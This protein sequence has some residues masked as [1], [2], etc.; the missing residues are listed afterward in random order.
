MIE[1]RKNAKK[2]EKLIDN[3][4]LSIYKYYVNLNLDKETNPG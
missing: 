4:E 3:D 1:R 2:R